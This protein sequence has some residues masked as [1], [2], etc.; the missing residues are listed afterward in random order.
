MKNL[1]KIVNIKFK[2]QIVRVC[3]QTTDAEFLLLKR[4]PSKQSQPHKWDLPGGGVEPGETPLQAAIRETKEETGFELNNLIPVAQLKTGKKLR[5]LFLGVVEK[6]QNP[7][8]DREHNDF[9]WHSKGLDI[10]NLPD[11]MHINTSK[12][13]QVYSEQEATFLHKMTEAH[14]KFRDLGYHS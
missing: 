2:P 7:I 5:I 13:I 9:E 3:L 4:S 14:D 11:N 12:L 1:A 10:S 6:I 8:L